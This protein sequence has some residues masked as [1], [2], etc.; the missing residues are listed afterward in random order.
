MSLLKIALTKD[1]LVGFG[2]PIL[3]VL[4][5]DNNLVLGGVSANCATYDHTT[6]AD[7]VRFLESPDYVAPLQSVS[8]RRRRQTLRDS[9]NRP[10]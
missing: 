7:T 6:V 2:E 5:H 1:F 8:Y 10:N 3:I 9:R 4:A